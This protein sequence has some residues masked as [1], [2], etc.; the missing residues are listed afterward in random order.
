MYHLLA[1]VIV[2]AFTFGGAYLLYLVTGLL[3]KLRVKPE[4]EE[5]GLDVSQHGEKAND[6]LTF[7]EHNP[8][9]K[10]YANGNGKTKAQ[11]VGLYQ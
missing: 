5:V 1:L 7:M 10:P 8:A 9:F 2:G 11:E 6:I 3:I 4:L